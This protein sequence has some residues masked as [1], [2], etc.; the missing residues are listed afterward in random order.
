MNLELTKQD[1]ALSV[2]N[3]TNTKAKQRLLSREELQI[4]V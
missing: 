1:E 2:L 3:K 4:E